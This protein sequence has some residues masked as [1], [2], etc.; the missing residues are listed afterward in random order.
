MTPEGD[1]LQVA[2][3]ALPA[4]GGRAAA[5]G[6][7]TVSVGAVPT[8][9]YYRIPRWLRAG[10]QHFASWRRASTSSGMDTEVSTPPRI[11]S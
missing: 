9:A 1:G 7:L 2:R 5:A 11:S 4:E 8:A 6:A 3:V 10:T